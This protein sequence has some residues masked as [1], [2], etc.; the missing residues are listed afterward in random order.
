METVDYHMLW[1][2]KSKLDKLP[3]NIKPLF[4]SQFACQNRNFSLPAAEEAVFLLHS[5]KKHTK[6]IGVNHCNNTWIC[7]VCSARKMAKYRQRIAVALDA[8]KEKGYKAM[9]FTFTVPHNLWYSTEDTFE[10][11]KNSMRKLQKRAGKQ[12][13]GRKFENNAW[14]R[15][16]KAMNLCHYVRMAEVTF[17]SNGCHPHYHALYW[18]KK[19]LQKAVDFEGEVAALWNK[20]VKQETKK[21]FYKT[22]TLKYSKEE[23]NNRVD[24]IFDRLKLKDSFYISKTKEGKVGEILSSDYI[25]GW[26]GDSELTSTER[27]TANEKHYTQW[28]LL[29]IASSVK[30]NENLS[31]ETAWKWFE[32]FAIYVKRKNFYRAKFSLSKDDDG[33]TINQIVNLYKQTNAYIEIIK[34]N[35]AEN[36]HLV[37][38]FN[39]QQW[40]KICELNYKIPMLANIIFLAY[41]TRLLKEYLESFGIYAF[42]NEA[43]KWESAVLEKFNIAA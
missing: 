34:K 26:G 9:M 14:S 15:F 18:T 29:E 35:S 33:F 22:K 21:Q 13:K 8:L 40:F 3:I 39:K 20:I 31:A 25:A 27:K 24:E 42:D 36:W 37:C 4:R 19:N 16:F 38:W 6:L 12:A 1:F 28:Q 41:D 17:G 43:H 7:P 23:I 10:I 32:E 30:P 2:L 5:N 11:L